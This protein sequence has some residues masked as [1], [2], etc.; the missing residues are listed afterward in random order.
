MGNDVAAPAQGFSFAFLLPPFI[1]FVDPETRNECFINSTYRLKGKPAEPP[2]YFWSLDR[3]Y[4]RRAQGLS[5][6]QRY[7]HPGDC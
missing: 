5:L 7:E 6:D 2:F 3:L 4:N 1:A